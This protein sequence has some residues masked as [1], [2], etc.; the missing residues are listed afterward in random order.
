MTFE[1][2]VATEGGWDGGNLKISINGGAFAIVPASAFTFNPYNANLNT[3]AQG[4]TDPLAGEPAFTGTDGGEVH[5][6]WGLS[7]I[8]LTKVGIAAGDNIQLRFD[9]GMDG[10]TGVDGWYLDNIKIL[11]CNVKKKD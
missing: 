5:G 8:D 11:S 2:Y 10:C 3:A 4:N 6:S 9:M 1:H 7:Q